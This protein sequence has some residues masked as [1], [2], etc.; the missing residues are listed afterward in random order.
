MPTF[1]VKCS[2]FNYKCVGS[3][4]DC[5]I[6]RS[7]ACIVISDQNK[8]IGHV[9]SSINN[10]SCSTVLKMELNCRLFFAVF[11]IAHNEMFHQNNANIFHFHIKC[12]IVQMQSSFPQNNK[13]HQTTANTGLELCGC[14]FHKINFFRVICVLVTFF[15]SKKARYF[16]LFGLNN[17]INSTYRLLKEYVENIDSTLLFAYQ[18][19]IP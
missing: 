13:L 14:E 18:H 3:N 7:N 15:L 19:E 4:H 11:E 16:N 1:E 6:L 9:F 10:W 17:W 2:K 8:I 5:I 12:W